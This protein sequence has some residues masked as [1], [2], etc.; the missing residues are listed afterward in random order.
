MVKSS[1]H[2]ITIIGSG[3]VGMSLATLLAQYHQ[4]TIVDIDKEKVKKINAGMSPV[5]DSMISDYL[6]H[7]DL[8]LRASSS[9]GGTIKSADIA[10][11]ATPTDYDDET[12]CFDT[13]SVDIVV[14]EILQHNSEAVIVIKSTIPEGHTDLLKS[15][16]K[17][18]H[19][20][21]SPEFLREGQALHDNLYP[22]RIVI[23]SKCNNAEFF[24]NI[25]R[26][27]SLKKD[28]GILFT[29][30]REAEAIK[31]FSNTY[32]AMRVAFFNELDTYAM[33]NNLNAR[34]IITGLSL[35]D[36]IGDHYNNPSFGYGGY[37][38][39]K[40]TKQ[41]LANFNG[42]PQELISAVINSNKTRKT[43]IA[44]KILERKFKTI[45]FYKLDMKKGSDNYRSSSILDVIDLVI[46]ADRKVIIFETNINNKFFNSIEIDND[47]ESF[48]QRADLVVTNRQDDAL[49]DIQDKVFTRDIF[50]EN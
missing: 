39:P 24:A 37:C 34:D 36:R 41:L 28:V 3:Y 44:N 13:S 5:K 48:K 10:V 14:E 20:I 22:S 43:F 33:S 30:S 6:T 29:S 9:L 2:N 42:I 38:L 31:L 45:G 1:S 21:F 32:L 25:L 18:N 11:I 8:N 23:G 12:R 27:A 19:I 16:Y 15:K 49:S 7:K 40:D 46:A 26:K 50:E 35:D 4:V 47:F 17:T